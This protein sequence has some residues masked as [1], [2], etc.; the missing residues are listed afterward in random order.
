MRFSES[1]PPPAHVVDKLYALSSRIILGASLEQALA[2]IYHE[3]QTVVP[4]DRIGFA[5]IDLR[6]QTVTSRWAHSRRVPKLRIGYSAPL[7]GSSL[8]L[9]LEHRR[10]RV[11]NDLR[12]Y[13]K[14]HPSSR[15]TQLITSEGVQSSMTCPLFIGEEPLG[16]L[17][18]SSEDVDTYNDFH[19]KVLLEISNQ[20]ALLLLTSRVEASAAAAMPV[21]H[22]PLTSQSAVPLSALVPGMVV[23]RAIVLD[24]G[25]VFIASGV[26]LTGQAIARLNTLESQGFLTIGSVDIR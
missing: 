23:E 20:L 9:V 2:F 10:P 19:V 24:N 22:E 16:F 17:F 26:E 25:R 12:A 8:A 11:M 7:A 14:L 6:S 15:S 3:F 13:L 21:V 5:E 1:L 18:F 4:F